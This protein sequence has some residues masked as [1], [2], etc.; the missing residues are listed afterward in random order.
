MET[1]LHEIRAK[2]NRELK[3]GVIP[4]HFA[5]NHSHVNYYVDLTGIKS[6]LKLA[7]AAGEQLAIPFQSTTVVDTIVCMEGTETIGAFL[8]DALSRSAPLSDRKSVV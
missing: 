3:I 5:T 7:K 8:A 4:G 1:R 6:R 2:G